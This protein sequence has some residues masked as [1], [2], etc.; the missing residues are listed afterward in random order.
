VPVAA[1][2]GYTNAGK[3]SLLNTMTHAN[4]LA[5]DKLFATLD[6]TVRRVELPNNQPLLL[7][8]TVGFIR[9]LPHLLVEAFKSTLEETALAD[10]LIEVVDVTSQSIEEEQKTTREVLAELGAEGKPMITVF[11]KVD[12]LDDPLRL[13]RLQRRHPDAL[14]VSARTGQGL[15]TLARQLAAAVSNDLHQLHLLLPH[16]RYDLLARLHSTGTVLRETYEE[17]GVHVT[18]NVPPDL[19]AAVAEFVH[20][21]P[22]EGVDTGD[23]PC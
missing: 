21:S 1:I 18:A 8:D 11:N 23:V 16:S 14:F 2:V 19:R 7:A 5:E 10:L 13:R 15:E 17:D 20:P 4:V 12:L 3:S 6:P 9:K 22:E